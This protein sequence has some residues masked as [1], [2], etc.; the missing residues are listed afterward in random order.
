MLGM[1]LPPKMGAPIGAETEGQD[2]HPREIF[3][4]MAAIAAIGAMHR[5]I[6]YI[7]E[8]IETFRERDPI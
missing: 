3:M 4:C 8:A 1:L 7:E 5:S 2:Q 6:H